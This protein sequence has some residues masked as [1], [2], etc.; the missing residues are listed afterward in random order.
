MKAAELSRNIAAGKLPHLLFLYGEEAFLLEEALAQSIN[1]AVADDDRDFNLN[2]FSAAD[3]AVEDVLEAAR[4]FPVFAPRR[5]VVVT[6]VER[7]RAEEYETLL[8]YV[9]NPLDTTCLVLC[10]NKIDKR[11]KF[12]TH[13]KKHGKL[14]EFK[15]LYPN[16]LPEFVAAR[17]GTSGRHFTEEALELFCSRVGTN[18]AEVVTE[19]EKLENYCG[20]D[21]VVIDVADVRAVV[22]DTRLE[23]IFDL[24]DAAGSG[25]LGTAL[26]LS[27]RLQMEGEHPLKI[28]TML[29]WH[30]RQLWKVS[31]LLE[32]G[33]S[34]R[35]ICKIARINPYFIQ[36]SIRQ[37]RLFDPA[38]FPAIFELFVELDMQLKSGG[39]QSAALIQ[40]AVTRLVELGRSTRA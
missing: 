3:S 5:C 14:V 6:D 28:L 1:A 11:K 25:K 15:P 24:T 7:L 27:E 33:T 32:Q 40:Q 9:K 10:A 35:E 39:G 17:A 2:V 30:F 36:K 8:E 23:S 22:S 37:A 38:A 29:V 12:F 20:P 31:S 18:L 34:E 4:M 19:L 26:L 13:F 21:T 16:Q